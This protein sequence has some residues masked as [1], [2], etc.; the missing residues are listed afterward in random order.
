MEDDLAISENEISSQLIGLEDQGILAKR[1]K[2]IVVGSVAL[3]ILFV[4]LII[5]IAASSSKKSRGGRGQKPDEDLKD[6]LGEISCTYDVQSKS[7]NTMLI[8]NEFKKSTNF[9][10]EI[11]GQKIKYAKDY[12]FEETGLNSVKFLLYEP[13]NMDFMFK[14]VSD[15]ISINMI[16]NNNLEIISMISAF[17]D[18]QRL[19][20]IIIHGFDTSKVTSMK[21]LFYR[22]SIDKIDMSDLST[23]SVT[24]M[25]YMFASTEISHLNTSTM[26]TSKVETMISMFQYC[27]SLQSLYLSNFNTENVKDNSLMMPS[28]VW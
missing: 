18:C 13:I 2:L 27:N 26:D 15:I 8:S 10:I 12:R 3:A 16:S 28:T 14:D 24:D 5:I 7:K 9:D 21:K 11:D 17:E 20:E 4:A 25:S 1:T 23:K 22:T 19:T 6:I